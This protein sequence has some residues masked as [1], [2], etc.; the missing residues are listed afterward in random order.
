[1]FKRGAQRPEKPHTGQIVAT[2]NGLT[3]ID[4]WKCGYKH[5]DPLPSEREVESYYAED[6]FYNGGNGVSDWLHQEIKEHN[7]GLWTPR[8]DYECGLIDTS[9]PLLDVGAGA[10]WFVR[11]YQYW[12]K[13]WGIEPSYSARAISEVGD[14]LYPNYPAFLAEHGWQSPINIRMALVLEH[15][16][17]PVREVIRYTKHLGREG[18]LLVVAPHEFSNLQ[19]RVGGYQWIVKPHL[20]YFDQKGITRVLTDAGLTV[21][22]VGATAPME[23]FVLAGKDYRKDAA[24]GRQLH[25]KRLAFEKRFGARAFGFYT[26]LYKLFG[27][28]RALIVVAKRG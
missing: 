16:V 4:C 22:R 9:L 20:N 11:H 28:G 8:H 19:K 27:W 7:A 1:M 21:E 17:D 13:A 10:G 24:L 12:N 3:V 5:L 23:L 18:R 15:L 6:Q 25:L 26:M 14:C 2:H